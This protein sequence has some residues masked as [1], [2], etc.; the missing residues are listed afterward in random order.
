MLNKTIPDR[1]S[2][3]TTRVQNLLESDWRFYGTTENNNQ[4]YQFSNSEFILV[5]CWKYQILYLTRISKEVNKS[6]MLN[7]KKSYDP[8]KL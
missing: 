2:L 3:F 4:S 5:R 6:F 1:P 7:D 8:Y